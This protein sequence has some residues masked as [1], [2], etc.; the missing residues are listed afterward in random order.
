M[1]KVESKSGSKKL[2]TFA[3]WLL[4]W[5]GLGYAFGSYV[6]RTLKDTGP[7]LEFDVSLSALVAG[8]ISVIY[9]LMAIIV[10]IGAVFPALGVRYLNTYGEDELRDEQRKLLV[11]AGAMAGFGLALLALVLATFE[12]LSPVAGAVGFFGLMIASL[13]FYW[14]LMRAMDELDWQMSNEAVSYTYYALLVIGGSWAAL[15]HLKLAE[16]PAML[17][18]LSMFWGL[19]LVSTFIA[20]GRRGLLDKS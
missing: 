6:G 8:G 15:G 12:L 1:N 11:S 17:D 9:L 7:A 4:V 10:G 14:P 19:M 20:A 2:L 16:G 18:W 13:G 5:T 3:V